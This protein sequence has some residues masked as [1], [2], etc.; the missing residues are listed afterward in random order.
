VRRKSRYDRYG[1]GGYAPYVPVA[2]RREQ[3]AKEVAR[4]RKKGHPVSPVVIEGRTIATTFWGKAWCRNLEA[5]SDYANRVPRGR[6]YVRNGSVIDLQIGEGRVTAL[7]S[8]SSIYTVELTI[9]PVNPEHWRGLCTDC[10]GS[11]DSL[12]ELLQGKLSKGVMERLCRQR[13]GLFP[14]PREIKLAC[15]CPDAAG[16]CKHVAAVLYG[17]G[18]RLDAAPELLFTLRGVEAAD[19]LSRVGGELPPTESKPSKNR[20]LK[21]DDLS[22]LFGVELEAPATVVP[23]DLLLKHLRARG[24][25]GA[26]TAELLLILPSTSRAEVKR[27]LDELREEGRVVLEGRTRGARWSVPGGSKP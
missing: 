13:E 4:L 26:P 18:A 5:Y 9:R 2:E 10:A 11:I 23:K 22:G 24:P 14:E 25:E 1:W 21:V 17:V 7:V 15:S 8:G 3:A 19:L 20:R 27:L 16:M 12:V 6:T